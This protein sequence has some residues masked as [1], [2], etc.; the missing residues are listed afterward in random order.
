M[1]NVV[2]TPSDMTDVTVWPIT[3]TPIPRV[4]K[5]EKWKINQKK[6]EWKENEKQLSLQSSILTV[7][8]DVRIY[9]DLFL[10]SLYSS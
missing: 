5:I 3:S 4:L 9:S 1:I 2:T 10:V 6:M 8:L 7:S